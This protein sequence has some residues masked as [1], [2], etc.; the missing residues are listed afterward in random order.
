MKSATF[1][2]VRLL[3]VVAIACA[4][5]SL[6]SHH[7]GAGMLV[8]AAP[9]TLTDIR[10][11]AKL[12]G[13]LRDLVVPASADQPESTPWVLFDTQQYPQ[14]GIGALQFFQSTAANLTDGTLSN[15]ANGQ[16]EKNSYFEMHRAFAIIHAV[17][18]ANA[19]VAITGAANDV[20][21]LHKTARAQVAW[22]VAN[23]DYGPFPLFF[24]GR[25]GG[26]VPSFAAYGTG[27]AANNAI[28]SGQTENNGGFPILGN[29]IIA[30]QTQF[31]ASMVF[32]PTAISAATYI[33]LAYLGVLHRQV[34]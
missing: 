31:K 2:F 8:A 26:P 27:T 34:R 11:F 5:S 33:T 9:L 19:T 1:L 4:V 29:Q 17:P 21:L 25:P 18:N 30:E 28:T 16:L 12:Y 22:R 20:E 32:N 7:A 15:F 14:A 24:F 10:S 6:L 3:A 23:K 13:T